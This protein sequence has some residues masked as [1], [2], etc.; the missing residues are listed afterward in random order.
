MQIKRFFFKAVIFCLLNTVILLAVLLFFSGRDRD[1]RLD[2]AYTESNLLV[3]G[4]DEHYDVALLGTSRG[5]VFSR[6]GNHQRVE[7]II[8]KRLINLAKGGGG[9]LMPAKVHLAHFLSRGNRVDHIV[10]LVDPWVFFSP[11][12]NEKNTFFLRDEPFELSI[13]WQLIVD[14][15]PLEQIFS[16]L[17]MTAVDDWQAISRYAGE[18]LT[19]GTL[20]KIDDRKLQEARQYYLQRYGEQSFA[21]YSQFVDKINEIARKHGSRITYIMLPILITDFPGIAEVDQKLQSAAAG[22]DHVSYYNLSTEMQDRHLFYDHM[23]FNKKGI[24]FFTRRFL[25][26][27]LRGQEPEPG[28]DGSNEL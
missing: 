11:I 10:Y 21:R 16:Y 4:E 3:S 12:N 5:R 15:F 14:R 27:I 28:Q 26:P 2:I 24:D 23:H 22:N 17:Q 1:V 9:G 20:G 19:E 18:G 25:D 7:A 13:L 6:D 8:G